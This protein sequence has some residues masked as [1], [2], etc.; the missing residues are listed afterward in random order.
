MMN[1][2]RVLL[3]KE[4]LLFGRNRL[5]MFILFFFPVVIMLFLP[6]AMTMEVKN[7]RVAVQDSDGTALSRLLISKLSHSERLVLAD[8]S[9]SYE[10]EMELIDEG[11]ADIVLALPRG[12]EKSFAQGKPLRVS[13]S[14]NGVDAIKGS[15]GSQYVSAVLMQTVSEY[16]GASS[17][18][19]LSV[20]NLYNPTLNY[21]FYM[22]PALMIMLLVILCGFLPALNIVLEKETGTAEQVNVSPV[23]RFTYIMSKVLPFW[24]MG[25]FAFTVG[26]LVSRYVYGLIP[27]GSLGSLYLAAALF[28][29]LIAGFAVTVA[30]FSANMLQT[31]F[32]MMF[33]V[34]I[35]L[36]MSGLM[37][38]VRSMPPWAFWLSYI[39]P[40]KYFIDIMRAVFLKGATAADLAFEFSALAFFTLLFVLMAVLSYKKRF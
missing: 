16:M 11:E 10:R 39:L 1:T 13:I 4:F 29:I 5:F 23:G 33:F 7:V 36:L 25:L 3:K 15:I 21:R 9:S 20:L 8:V 28:T 31:I 2:L 30:N 18:E 14:A 17:K 35:F 34:I 26:I 38:P 12:Y 32:M 19:P 6:L 27:Q 22:I 37:T 24:L 40:P